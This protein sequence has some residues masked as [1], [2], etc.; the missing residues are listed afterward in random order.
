MRAQARAGG[1]VGG[2]NNF[3]RL[4]IALFPE[5]QLAVANYILALSIY[6]CQSFLGTY[7]KRA[8]DSTRFFFDV[9]AF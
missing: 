5:R 2:E 6:I 4:S 1:I 8:D 7:K 3:A 9:Y